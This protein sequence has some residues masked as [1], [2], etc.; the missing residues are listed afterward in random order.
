MEIFFESDAKNNAVLCQF[1]PDDG[2]DTLVSHL[3]ARGVSPRVAEKDGQKRFVFL[4]PLADF[5]ALEELRETQGD[6]HFVGMECSANRRFRVGEVSLL[7]ALTHPGQGSPSTSIPGPAG[8]GSN[9]LEGIVSHLMKESPGLSFGI[10]LH[11]AQ[12]LRPDLAQTVAESLHE[13][14]KRDLPPWQ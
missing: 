2:G 6:V 1:F 7:D 14:R 3:R 8:G 11:R 5:C 10:A 13:Y 12:L 4:I 9:T